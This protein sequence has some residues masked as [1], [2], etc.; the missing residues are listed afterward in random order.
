MQ[1]TKKKMRRTVVLSATY[2]ALLAAG[3][4][5]IDA[6][7]T[8]FDAPQ[9]DNV[10]EV[11]YLSVA[12]IL[13]NIPQVRIERG[14]LSLSAIVTGAAAILLNPVDATLVGLVT[15]LPQVRRSP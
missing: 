11:I 14:R 10:L 12:V 1:L 5:A 6:I 13:M 2:L 8:S 9:P 7:A 3:V 4:A 15:S